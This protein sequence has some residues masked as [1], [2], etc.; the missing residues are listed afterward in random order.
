MRPEDLL[1][2]QYPEEVVTHILDS[3]REIERNFQLANWKTAELDAGHFVESIRRALDSV[4]FGTYTPFSQSLGSFNQSILNKY[5]NATGHESLRILIPRT[6]FSVY[7]IRNKRGVGHIGEISPNE[8]DATYILHSVKW[9]LA[10]LIR[11]AGTTSPKESSELIKT[12]VERQVEAIWDDGETFM[13]LDTKMPAK[14]KVLVVLYRKNNILDITLQ[15]LVEYQNPSAFKKILL[16]LKKEKLI[17]YTP[18][19]ICKLSPLGSA[20]VEDLLSKK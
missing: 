7:C 16:N 4:L 18:D 9:V 5:E 11:L 14:D 13:V 10:E 6:L 12:I 2:S 3:Y 17:D 19:K 15:K 8:L 1:K 20:K